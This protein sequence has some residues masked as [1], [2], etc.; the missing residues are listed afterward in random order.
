MDRRK[1]LVSSAGAAILADREIWAKSP[2]G[3]Q[4]RIA[5]GDARLQI[6]LN[7]SPDGLEEKLFQVD[8]GEL[9]SLAG[10]PWVADLNG[11]EFTPKGHRVKLVTSDGLTPARSAVFEGDATGLSWTL[12]YEVTGPGRITKTLS[13][14]PKGDGVLRRVLLWNGRS[15]KEPLVART[16]IQDIAAFYRHNGHGLFVSLDFP[17]S[18]IG[19]EKGLTKVS[20]PPY[21]EVKSGQTYTCHSLTMG[22][23]QLVGAERYG[24]DL[25]EVAA[26]DA[27]IQERYQPRFERPMFTTGCINNRYTQVRGDVVYYTMKDNP[28]LGF[29]LNLLRRE[30]A[31]MPKLGME[32]CQVFPGVFDW[33]ADDPSPE[34]VKE[35]MDYARSLGVRMG[36]Y[37]ASNS[38]FVA[39]YNEYRNRLDRPDWTMKDKDGKSS[40]STFCFGVPGF[41]QY[42]IDTVVPNCKKYG[43]EIHCLDGL[44]LSPCYATNHG[45]PVGPDSFY[46]QVRGLVRLLEAI[47]SVSPQMMTWSNSGSWKELLPKLAWSNH[48][49]YLTD[50]FIVTPWQGLNMTRLLD[51]ARREQMVS[52]HYTHFLPYRFYTNCQYFFCQN[53]IVPDVRNFEYGALSS[54][55]VT[56]NLCLAEV[57]PWLDGLTAENQDR[58]I[59]FYKRWTD[60]LKEH[61]ELWKKT[62][63]AGENPGVGA[64][65]IYS[66]AA[67]NRGFVFIVNPQYWGRTVEVQLDSSMGFTATGRCEIRELYP[68][69]RLRL[70]AQGPFVALGTKL[71]IHVPAQQVLVLEVRPTP[72]KV[73]SPRVY[74]LP[75]SI[76]PNRDGYQIKTQGPQGHSERFAVLLPPSS[77]GVVAV[78]VRPDV[79]KQPKRLWAPTPLKLLAANE[80]GALLEVTFRRKP[81]PTD[82]RQW[83]VRPGNLAEGVAAQWNANFAGIKTLEFPI[84]VDVQ[85]SDLELPLC[86]KLA[87]QLGLGPLANFCGAYIENAFSEIQET[88]IDLKTGAAH[89]PQGRL[90]TA[91]ALPTRLALDPLAK[92]SSKG[93]WLQTSFYL[94][95][96]NS[97]GAEPAFDEHPRLVL[98]LLRHKQVKETKAWINGIPLLVERYAYPRNRRL[99][100]HYA[101]LVGSEARGEQ[102]NTLVIHLQC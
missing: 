22:A 43:F 74:G 71:A 59:A 86:D 96:I 65:E 64:V 17:Y 16:K 63:H 1:F 11:D 82:L 6:E 67:G 48:N 38:L 7:Y 54:I 3:R 101:D 53:S 29:H 36:D 100:C 88:W 52:L 98:P 5:V 78:E 75:G 94:P 42:Y 76:E 15:D 14:T 49:L 2:S 92:D 4:G 79:P 68:V 51:D 61:Y 20:Y 19:F 41:V 46:Q 85:Q 83:Q 34:T 90:V 102:D 50:P 25:G 32:Y 33:V 13:L 93:W 23:V 62:Y 99:A 77:P 31:L 84:F 70:T 47:D 12:K 72:E 40:Q 24:Y 44:R 26:M 56:P 58:V 89:L 60:F 30:L 21:D 55:A 87:D 97:G 28:T 81:A 91:E 80:Q 8:R 35:M 37:S 27:Y 9:P 45:H 73:E 57:R 69:E 39:H 18:R 10:V 95:F 66:H